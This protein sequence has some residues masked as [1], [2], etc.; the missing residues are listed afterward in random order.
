[1]TYARHVEIVGIFEW[2]GRQARVTEKGHKEQ[3]PNQ[4]MWLQVCSSLFSPAPPSFSCRLFYGRT[5]PKCPVRLQ[6]INREERRPQSIATAAYQCRIMKSNLPYRPVGWY[7]VP[8]EPGPG[9]LGSGLAL[10]VQF[11]KQLSLVRKIL[12]ENWADDY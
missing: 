5:F 6:I 4:T 2:R 1:M 12:Y 11:R 9:W 3:V 7:M 8:Q 10:R